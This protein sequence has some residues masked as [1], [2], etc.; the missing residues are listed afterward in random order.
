MTD[1]NRN[2]V[3]VDY[4]GNGAEETIKGNLIHI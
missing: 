2:N 1:D 3:N 4:K